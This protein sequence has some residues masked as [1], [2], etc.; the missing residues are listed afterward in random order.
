MT[1]VS[2]SDRR[3]AQRIVAAL[4]KTMTKTAIA[5]AAGVQTFYISYIEKGTLR[6]DGD[7]F[8]ATPSIIRKILSLE[9]QC[10]DLSPQDPTKN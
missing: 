8:A 10:P 9:S 3:K 6:R 7:R 2:F 5:K 4:H 1:D